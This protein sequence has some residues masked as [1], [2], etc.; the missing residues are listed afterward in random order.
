M[1]SRKE[2]VKEVI[3]L[4]IIFQATYN[5]QTQETPKSGTTGTYQEPTDEDA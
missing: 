3:R 4:E 1:R 5:T 2:G